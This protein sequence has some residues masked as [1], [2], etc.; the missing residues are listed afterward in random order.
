MLYGGLN[1]I[2][3]DGATIGH[4][5]TLPYKFSDQLTHRIVIPQPAAFWRSEVA[6]TVGPLRT[7]LDYAMDFEYWI[8]IG[9]QF[10]ILQIP[11]IL[12]QFRIWDN[13]KGTA[14]RGKWGPE[15]I[16]VLDDLYA[17]PHVGPGLRNLRGRA[18]AG[19]LT[20]GAAWFVAAGDYVAARRWVGRA[21]LTRSGI[22]L[23]RA[24]W[25]T[26]LTAL[27]GPY[28]HGVGRRAKRIIQRNRDDTSRE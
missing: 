11:Q 12:A 24:W 3:D 5:D 21:A 10:Q 17:D 14:Q 22:L 1:I 4:F 7:D 16:R 26:A 15:F 6:A 18:Y 28:M 27:M 13:N 8:R 20:H 23:S 9:R 25:R 2:N 19:A